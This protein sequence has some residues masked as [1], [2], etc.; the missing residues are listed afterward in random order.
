MFVFEFNNH[1]YLMNKQK[2]YTV[3]SLDLYNI[4]EEIKDFLNFN[5]EFIDLKE[6]TKNDFEKNNDFIN[7]LFLILNS[8]KLKAEKILDSKNIVL[9]ENLPISIIKLIEKI[10]ISSLKFN[11]RSQSEIEVKNYMID[12]N[13]RKI[14]KNKIE[15]KLTEREIEIILFL[16][17][18]KKPQ[19]VDDLQTEIWKQK[20][21]LET[22][23]VETH[24]YRLRKKINEKFNDNNFIKS[25]ELG[26][27]V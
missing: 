11:F 14:I 6:I 20:K 23:T 16:H 2:I 26:Y 19:N 25:N 27:F 5:I 22:H 18:K 17:N 24:I 10:N 21:E 7:S 12:L 1:I 8:D 15:L 9:L 13:E 4:L 3:N